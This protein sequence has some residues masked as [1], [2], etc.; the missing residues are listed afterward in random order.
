MWIWTE[1]QRKWVC[2]IWI[3]GKMQFKLII[4]KVMDGTG[5]LLVCAVGENSFNGKMKLTMQEE[6]DPT[7]L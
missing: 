4:F 6:D 2:Y 5:K 3:K 1:C 7:P